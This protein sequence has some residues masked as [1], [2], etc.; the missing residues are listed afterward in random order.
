MI[1]KTIG[2][3][4][5]N[6][7]AAIDVAEKEDNYDIAGELYDIYKSLKYLFYETFPYDTLSDDE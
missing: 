4:C 6:V 1:H 3:L 2:L 5:A 7:S